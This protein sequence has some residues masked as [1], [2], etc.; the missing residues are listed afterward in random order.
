[1]KSSF[2]GIASLLTMDES[3]IAMCVHHVGLKAK[4]RF[5]SEGRAFIITRARQSDTEIEMR[6]GETV[7][8][9][10]RAQGAID[11]LLVVAKPAMSRRKSKKCA[12]I[13]LIEGQS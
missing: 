4:S 6:H 11:G 1:M 9:A 7:K 13:I 5:E 10:H 2:L 12:G 8:K 3:E